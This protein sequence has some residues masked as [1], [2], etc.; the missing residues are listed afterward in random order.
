MGVSTQDL[1]LLR[2][3]PVTLDPV[4]A[5]DFTDVKCGWRVMWRDDADRGTWAILLFLKVMDFLGMPSTGW[6]HDMGTFS[7]EEK[8]EAYI[9]AMKALLVAQGR[10]EGRWS[11]YPTAID[12]GFPLTRVRPKWLYSPNTRHDLVE[13]YHVISDDELR[14][15]FDLLSTALT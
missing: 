11:I 15:I 10:S 7:C 8:A 6:F 1:A 3:R 4:E 9:S 2:A 5:Y 14:A 13:G 12:K